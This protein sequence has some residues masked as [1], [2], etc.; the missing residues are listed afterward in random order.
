[1]PTQARSEADAIERL[2]RENE[3]TGERFV[4]L[5]LD[6][7]LE[8]ELLLTAGGKWDRRLG[9]YEGDAAQRVVVRLHPGQKRA[10]EWFKSWLAA[11]GDRRVNP[12]PMPELANLE[13]FDFDAFQL[14]TDP[15]HAYAAL[16]AGGRRGGKTWI[17]VAI[18]VCYAVMY[19]G[20]IVWVVSPNDQKHAEV[21]RYLLGCIADEWLDRATSFEYDFC[22]G[23]QILLKGAH[24]PDLLKEGKA[25]LIILNEGTLM[26]RRTFTVARGNIVDASGLVIVCSNPPTEKKDQTWV[27]DFAA[28]ARAGRRAAVFLEFDPRKNPHIDRRALFSMSAELDARTFKIEVLGQFLGPPDAVAWNWIRLEN[29][30]P[31]PSNYLDVT[32]RFLHDLEGPGIEHFVGLDVQRFPYIGGP[33]YKL[34]VEPGK[35]VTADTVLAWIVGE[36]VLDGGDEVDFCHDLREA[37]LDPEQTLIVCDATAEYQHSR[38]R[39]TDSPP[40]E[41]SGRGSFSIIRGEGYRRIV[42][43]DRR[44]RRKNPELVDRA[45]AFTSMIC[46]VLGERR[47]FADPVKAPKTCAAIRDWRVL[48]GKPNR[49]QYEA[50]LGDGASYPMIRLFPRRM[51]SGNPRVVN[52]PIAE[53]VDLTPPANV[54][55]RDEQRFEVRSPRGRRSRG[56]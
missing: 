2:R 32:E 47:L 4:D 24:N 9:D 3:V 51:R 38:R 53:R 10:V 20:A 11:H 19:P 54:R 29:E 13:E 40:P 49:T 28:E 43:P 1:M 15:A 44:M 30:I 35:P 16:F 17:A 6:F 7:E 41:W 31:V 33:W 56:L 26:Q 34:F 55:D 5:R 23:S 8:S 39:S 45:R 42:P 27:S 14:D 36:T 18:A 12:P 48:H 50:H 22:N 52:D 21:R 37:G 25:N 46:N